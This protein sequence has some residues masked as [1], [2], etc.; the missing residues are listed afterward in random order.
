MVGGS[1]F[2]FYNERAEEEYA[3]IDVKEMVLREDFAGAAAA[4]EV[5]VTHHPLTTAVAKARAEL[6][7]IEA[8]R[9]QFEA[10]RN[11]DRALR[12]RELKRLRDDY[13]GSWQRHRELFLGGEPEQSLEVLARVRELVAKAAAPED[14]AWGLE[15]GVETTWTKLCEFLAHAERLAGEYQQRIAAEDWGGARTLALQLHREFENTRS[16]KNAPVP[17]T[18]LT[19]PPGATLS[20]GGKLLL[21]TVDG[22]QRATTT[23]AVVLCAAAPT[24]MVATL[25][26][27]EPR[28][29][30]VDARNQPQLDVVLEIVPERRVSFDSALQT[31]AGIGEGWL[32]V[33]LRGGRLGLA[34]TDGSARSTRELSGLRAVDST[35]RVQNGRVFFT[36]NENTIECLGVDAAVTIS[37]WP[38]MLSSPIAT[39]LAVAE[40][41]VAAV[42]REGVLHCWEQATARAVFSV[43]LDSGTAGVPT[44][45]RR[46]VHVGTADGRVLV[47]DATDGSPVASLRSPAGVCTRVL[48][49]RGTLFFGG[50]DGNVRAVDIDG[51]VRWT[52]AVGRT[53]GEGD[54]ALAKGVLLV[55]GGGNKLL[56]IDRATGEI[57]PPLALDGEA[58]PGLRVRGSQALLQVRRP[59]VRKDPVR[60]VLVA[61]DVATL[62][63]AWEF[64]DSGVRPG[65]PC[66]DELM[67]ALPSAAGEVVLFR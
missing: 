65:Q 59:K 23:P 1:G 57:A 9:Q 28:S 13:K 41:R 62:T 50:T 44:I 24:A 56:A 22:Q 66:T 48:S 46:N 8:A 31:G 26:G 54:L 29:F 18:I 63:V 67:I 38:V 14:V 51:R 45:E 49:D 19:R 6:Q 27:F 39:D 15:Q 17:V 30:V 53:L 12:D 25:P 60:D 7:Q 33:G 58:Q 4:Y 32:A 36:T 2:W 35:P 40:G 55:I 16:A 61:V 42:D 34:R 64:V 37:G 5:F 47:F 3:R 10:R 11:S 52:V 20:A 21:R 43:S